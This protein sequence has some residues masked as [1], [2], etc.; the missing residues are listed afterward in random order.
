M[1][2]NRK[3]YR[4]CVIWYM[5]RK[6]YRTTCLRYLGKLNPIIQFKTIKR[7]DEFIANLDTLTPTH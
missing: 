7:L 2:I 3:R 4:P 5:S 1:Q 6:Q